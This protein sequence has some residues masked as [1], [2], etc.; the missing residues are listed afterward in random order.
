[1][2][3][4][5]GTTTE[6]KIEIDTETLRGDIRDMVL[7]EFKHIDK[8]WTKMKEDDQQR[9]ISRATDIADTLVRTAV[10]LIAARDL[11]ALPIT[12]GKI[13]VDGSE[14]KGAFECYADDDN[15]L[16]IRH[17]QGARAMFVLA[18]PS[19]YQGEKAP[20]VPDVVGDLSMPKGPDTAGILAAMDADGHT[21]SAN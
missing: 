1:M 20:A 15:L 17:L 14:C 19:A 8:P 4:S 11:P 16:R 10:D 12:V 7:S 18:S 5:N 13:V 21:A 3:A 9:L 2:P 6:N